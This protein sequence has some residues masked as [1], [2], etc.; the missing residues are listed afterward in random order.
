MMSSAIEARPAAA[1]QSGLTAVELCDETGLMVVQRNPIEFRLVLHFGPQ[2]STPCSRGLNLR[3]SPAN[4]AFYN[5][6]HAFHR[7]LRHHS[8]CDVF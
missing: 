4:R 1:S 6:A 3:P 7:H 5:G 8:F 2:L